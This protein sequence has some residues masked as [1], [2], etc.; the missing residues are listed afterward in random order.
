[1]L[2]SLVNTD[3]DVHYFVVM[4][5]VFLFVVLCV[6]W[7]LVL[8][9]LMFC[10]CF[11]CV[12]RCSALLRGAASSGLAASPVKKDKAGEDIPTAKKTVDMCGT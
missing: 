7:R 2:V 12:C 5:V 4:V 8:L 3:G 9:F 6:L 11:L 1:M 10:I